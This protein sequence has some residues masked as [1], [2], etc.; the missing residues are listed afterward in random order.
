MIQESQFAVAMP[1]EDQK[2]VQPIGIEIDGA[3]LTG[4]QSTGPGKFQWFR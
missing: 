1:V 3:K 2:I 4:I